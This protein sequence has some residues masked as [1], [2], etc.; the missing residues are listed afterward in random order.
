MN[1]ISQKRF[2]LDSN[3]FSILV[4]KSLHLDELK[5]VGHWLVV[6]NKKENQVRYVVTD[7]A[8]DCLS[9]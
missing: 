4:S 2:L 9:G 3:L 1:M 5:N 7:F 6:S 8:I